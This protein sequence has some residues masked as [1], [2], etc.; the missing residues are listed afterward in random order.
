MFGFA[1]GFITSDF[2]YKFF[3]EQFLYIGTILLCPTW[4][5][6]AL[7]WTGKDKWLT[8]KKISLIYIV[9][10]LFLFLIFT[11]EL[12]HLI[13]TRVDFFSHGSIILIDYGYSGLWWLFTLYCYFLI[14]IGVFILMKELINL[15]RIYRKQVVVLLAGTLA[16]WVANI[17]YNIYLIPI[18]YNLDI[19]PIFFVITCVVYV[20]GF[21]KLKLIE[22]IPIARDIVFE[23]M[24]DPVFVLDAQDRIVDI[25]PVALKIFDYDG[26]GPIGKKVEEVFSNQYDIVGYI[27]D[28]KEA[29]VEIFVDTN[30]EK[31]YFDM[32]INPL[33][34]SHDSFT[35]HVIS[36]RDITDHKKVEEE[37]RSGAEHLRMANEML[38]ATRDELR[39][40]NKELEQKVEERTAK[41]ETLLKHKDDFIAQLGHD[42]KSPLTPLIGLL[43]MVEEEETDP[44]LKELIR[45]SIRNVKYMR[46]L[47]VKTLQLER[48]NSPNTVF[49]IEEVDVVELVDFI[50]DTKQLIFKEAEI[51][52]NNNINKRLVVEG[53]KLQLSEVFD[54]LLTNAAKFTSKGGNV[55]IDAVKEKGKV[56]ISVK[57]TGIG[58]T[59]QQID[60]VFEE[61]YKVDPARHD[62]ES[63]GLGLS[64]CKRIVEK[65]GGK[66]WAESP[67]LNKGTMFKFSLPYNQK[68]R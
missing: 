25:N 32:K 66:I 20:W 36:L 9:P 22:T 11:D 12:H 58:M 15:R 17:L 2:S 33:Y 19:T 43:P 45:V 40:L 13:F 55:T 67:G 59:Q 27:Q 41:I 68:K 3:I 16:P 14:L 50:I 29:Q 65:H 28:K 60:H 31:R 56:I 6:F 57:D 62:L 5:I 49:N 18:L 64:I 4:L 37:R 21:S 63:S 48:L 35:G 53:D 34:G 52:V 1:L 7:Q 24:S 38:T 47:V 10:L 61:F 26:S 23:N 30:G 46:D 54:N 44:K 51:S 39:D 42:L 8:A